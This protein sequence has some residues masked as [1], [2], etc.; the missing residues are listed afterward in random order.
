MR[1]LGGVEAQ[2]AGERVEHLRRRLDVAALLEPRVPGQPDPGELGDLLAP[3]AR[4]APPAVR[5]KADVLRR[6]AARAGVRRK[7]ASS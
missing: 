5:G 7:S 4:R 1:A 3:Q 2:D 6:H